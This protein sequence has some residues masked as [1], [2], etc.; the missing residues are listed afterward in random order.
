MNLGNK[1][2]NEVQDEINKSQRDYFLREQMKA[3]KHELGEDDENVEINELK[4]RIE[5]GNFPEE[6]KENCGEGARQAAE[7]ASFQRGIYCCPYLS[8][9]A[10]RPAMEYFDG[11]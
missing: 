4:K 8:R 9:L 3:I 2:Q 5:E 1:I 10:S 6:T 7:N 11:R